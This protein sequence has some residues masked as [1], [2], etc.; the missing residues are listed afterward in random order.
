MPLLIVFAF[1][2]CC[3]PLPW[4]ESALGL[5]PA[6][7]IATGLALQLG[8]AAVGWRLMARVARG[9]ARPDARPAALALY[10]RVRRLWPLVTLGTTATVLAVVGYAR[11][12]VELLTADW[13]G[14]GTTLLLPGAELAVALP[15][16]LATASNWAGYYFAERAIHR[17]SLASLL[18]SGG[19]PFWSLGGYLSFQ[20]RQLFLTAGLPVLLLSGQQSFAR[21]AP[22]SANTGEAQAV[23]VALTVGLFVFLPVMVRALWGFRP[24]R[25][26]PV[27]DLVEATRARLDA[28]ISRVFEWPTRM[29]VANAIVLGPWRRVRYVALTD[30]ILDESPPAELVAVFGHEVGHA[31]HGHLPFYAAFLALSSMTGAILVTAL[32][33]A[34]RDGAGPDSPAWDES[35]VGGI[36]A[37]ALVAY[38]FTVFGWLSRRC[39][40]QADVYGARAGSCA[41]PDCRGH[42]AQTVLLRGP[43]LAG[44]G[45]CRTGSLALAAALVRVSEWGGRDDHFAEASWRARLVGWLQA[46]QHGPMR[47]RIGFLR[48]LA[49]N[50]SLAARADRSAWRARWGLMLGLALCVAVAGAAV[51]F[52]RLAAEMGVDF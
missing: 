12:V 13:S 2:L 8:V 22:R 41:D 7:A 14:R 28:P 23:S 17:T 15:L 49:E 29:T 45:V 38:L 19:R 4:P 26:G 42:T 10:G 5:G 34:W 50:P 43:E 39:E 24:L 30:R 3:L 51:G 21:A 20:A 48:S 9:V 40:R 52:W 6:E 11:A 31:R 37:V 18:S 25:P 36:S 1:V 44:R 32:E 47:V 35:W 27:R 33:L 16:A 46:W